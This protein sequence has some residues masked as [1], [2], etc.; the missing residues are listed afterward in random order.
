MNLYQRLIK[1]C[2]GERN[3]IFFI[4]FSIIALF[5]F[6]IFVISSVGIAFFGINYYLALANKISFPIMIGCAFI[7]VAQAAFIDDF[8]KFISKTQ[9]KK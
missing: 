5:A 2:N 1:N 6:I 8:Q 4:H 7:S 9:W 3:E